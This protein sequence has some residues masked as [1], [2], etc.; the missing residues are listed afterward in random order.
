[1]YSSGFHCEC[2]TDIY[3]LRALYCK[4]DDKIRRILPVWKKLHVK[5]LILL[6]PYIFNDPFE[7]QVS[8]TDDAT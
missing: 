1:M 8:V 2:V 6:G 3:V 7:L 5:V 4:Y